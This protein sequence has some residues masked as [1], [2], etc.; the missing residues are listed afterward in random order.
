MLIPCA[1]KPAYIP[2]PCL[3]LLCL[4]FTMNVQGQT[5]ID[6]IDSEQHNQIEI[7]QIFFNTPVQ[8]LYHTPKE[9]M[10]HALIGLHS[11]AVYK[12]TRIDQPNIPVGNSLY[13]TDFELFSEP[14][15]NP[16]L[17]IQFNT[18]VNLEVQPGKHLRSLILNI[19]KHNSFEAK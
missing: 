5:L 15:F 19:N 6:R 13:I 11:G 16:H 18:K 7:V 8:Y 9:K 10:N 17:Y 3:L 14:G 2:L 4:F 1:P 12:N